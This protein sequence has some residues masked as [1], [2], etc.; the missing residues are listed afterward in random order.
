ML[1]IT[2]LH[3]LIVSFVR[4]RLFFKDECAVAPKLHASSVF[5]VVPFLAMSCRVQVFE[6]KYIEY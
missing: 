5:I 1:S 4:L 3:E 2:L 6:N